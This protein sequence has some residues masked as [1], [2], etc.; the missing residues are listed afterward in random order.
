VAA[1]VNAFKFLDDGAVGPFTGFRWPVGEWVDAGGVDPCLSGIHA[2]RVRH[3][4]VWLGHELWEIE[5]AGEVI[6]HQRKV[7][8]VRGRLIRRIDAWNEQV[9]QDFGRFCAQRTRERV[10]FLPVLSGYVAD[11]DNFVA[12][13]RIPIAGFAAARAAERRDGPDAYEEERL[14]Q[15]GWLADRLGLEVVA[16]ELKGP[17]GRG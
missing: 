17:G 2:C 8:A 3:L 9:A 6:E 1:G 7:V 13:H 4:P 14:A 16:D 12:Q 5:L 15:A 11:V 10:G